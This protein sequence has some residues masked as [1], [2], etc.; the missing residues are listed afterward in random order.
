MTESL[1][2]EQGAS[3][4]DVAV[5]GVGDAGAGR[6]V[7]MALA[8]VAVLVTGGVAPAVGQNVPADRAEISLSFAP[9]VK[10][11]VPAVVNVYASRIV[12]QQPQS[13][14]R[15]DPLFRRFFGGE[16]P[17]QAA[18]RQRQLQSLGSGVL[19]DPS[20]I[21]VTNNHVI[22]DADAVRVALSDRREFD[23]DIVLKD[24]KT[25]LAVLK[26]RGADEPLPALALADSDRLEVGDL[27]L[28]VG[29]PFGVG[30]TVT[31]G[32]VSALARTQVGISDYQFFIQTDAAINPGNSG[33]ALVDVAGNVV[34]INTAIYSRSGGNIGIGFAIPANMV[35]QV[36]DAARQGGVIHRPWLGATLQ[37]VSA[38][39]ADGLGLRRPEGAIVTAVV[40]GGPAQEA[41]LRV[42]DLIVSVDGKEIDDPDGFGY[43]FTTRPL[44]GSVKLGL[45]RGGKTESVSVALVEA[46]EVPARDA[47]TL[48]GVSPLGG[49]TIVNLSPAANDELG[50]P[51]DRR[52]V[53]VSAVGDGSIAGRVGF[54]RGDILVEINGA[55]PENAAAAARALSTRAGVWRIA[56]ERDGRVLQIVLRG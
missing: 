5:R 40:E 20:G 55:A 3:K 25:D 44:G 16:A 39:I 41:G 56:V 29:N 31:Q 26:V 23:A 11:V 14:F 22:K 24:E 1:G 37:T 13:P 28:A 27:V 21:I 54:R 48:S 30:Q 34:G 10:K 6:R 47:R 52:G 51:G 49:A 9:V 33:G 4:A 46:P 17:G 38:D 42:G 19:V 8:A 43:R 53:A 36:V 15:D 7:G 50:L 12:D 2:T 18:P 32:I 45:L 35:R